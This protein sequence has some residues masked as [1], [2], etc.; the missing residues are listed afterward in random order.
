MTFNT[1]SANKRAQYKNL[2]LRMMAFYKNE[3]LRVEP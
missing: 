3:D 2:L 1:A